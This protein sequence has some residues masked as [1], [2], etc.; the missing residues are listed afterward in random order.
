MSNKNPWREGGRKKE[1]HAMQGRSKK[2][3][4]VDERK[5]ENQ[6]GIKS[7]D[8]FAEERKV[9]R[10]GGGRERGRKEG[11]LAEGGKDGNERRRKEGR[12]EGRRFKKGSGVKEDRGLPVPIPS[13]PRLVPVPFPSCP[14][15]PSIGARVHNLRGGVGAGQTTGFLRRVN[16]L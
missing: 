15:L 2:D 10:E 16:H 14:F 5:S 6:R 12:K 1:A 13:A 11:I 9:G 4:Q 7:R 8:M 3:A